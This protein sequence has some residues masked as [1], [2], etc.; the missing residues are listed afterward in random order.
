MKI[1][2]EIPDWFVTNLKAILARKGKVW[3][4]T[5]EQLAQ[6]FFRWKMEEDALPFSVDEEWRLLLDDVEQAIDEAGVDIFDE[7]LLTLQPSLATA[8][9]SPPAQPASVPE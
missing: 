2:I 8:P 4:W 1:T 6:A 7:V 9:T 5:N 3:R